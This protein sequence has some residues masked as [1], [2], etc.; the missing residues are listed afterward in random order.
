MHKTARLAT[1]VGTAL[2]LLTATGAGAA[3]THPATATASSPWSQTDY[4]AALSRANLTETTLTVSTASKIQYLRSELARPREPSGGCFD[5]PHITAPVLTGGSLYAIVNGILIRYDAATGRVVWRR[6]PDPTFSREYFSLAVAGG[7]VV[8]GAQYCGSVSQPLGFML[9]FNATTGK[10]AWSRRIPNAGALQDLVV[11]GGFVVADGSSAAAGLTVAVAKVSTGTIVWTRGSACGGQLMVVEQAVIYLTGCGP[12]TA[13]GRNLTTGALLW[14]HPGLRELQ[15]GDSDTTAGRHAFVI[16]PSGAIESLDPLT[17]KTQYTLT[18]AASVD[19][20]DGTQAY[21]AC[22]TN[23]CAYN[24]ATGAQAWQTTPPAPFASVP[25]AEAGGLL[26]LN[27]G[28]MLNAATGQVLN[29]TP[30]WDN[31]IA[32]SSVVV[33]DGRIAAVSDPRILDLY[34]LPGS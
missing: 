6:N 23:V 20:V 4:N 22:G 2:A 21:G 13:V 34:G 1:I 5:G 12:F 25:I 28:I 16:D 7:L 19:V 33:G 30:L 9:A 29:I 32:A 27:A 8:V 3:V 18:G 14:R 11:T 15:R 10:P 24:I 31:A 17:G 26:Y